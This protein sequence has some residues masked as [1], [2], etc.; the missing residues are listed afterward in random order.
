MTKTA[1]IC[2][3]KEDIKTVAF[4]PSRKEIQDTGFDIR[5]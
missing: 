4:I 3:C 1:L 5:Q 2:F